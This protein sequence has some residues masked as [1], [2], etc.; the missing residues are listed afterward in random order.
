MKKLSQMLE[1]EIL[2]IDIAEMIAEWTPSSAK[3]NNKIIERCK[4]CL[5]FLEDPS[6]EVNP[7]SEIIEF[8]LIAL[9][10][11]GEYK[12]VTKFEENQKR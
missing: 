12:V 6:A 8:V 10:N 4:E 9:I 7:R 3:N 11:L 2:L 5:R 1:W